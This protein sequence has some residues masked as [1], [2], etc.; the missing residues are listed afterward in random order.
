MLVVGAF[1]AVEAFAHVVLTP[2][3]GTSG[4]P[5]Q[6]FSV[7]APTEKDIPCVELKIEFPDEWKDAGGHVDRIQLD[8]LWEYSLERDE[9]NWVKSVTWT[10]SQ[11]PADAFIKFDMIMSLPKLLGMQQIKA[12]QTYSDGSVVS[13]VEDRTEEGVEKPAAG[14]MLTEGRGGRPGGAGGGTSMLSLGLSGLL[15]GLIGAGLVLVIRRGL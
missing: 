15:G 5:H 10:G 12:F 4:A 7:V 13:W 14:L 8:P 1:F 11:A 9:D 2:F 6:F 3:R